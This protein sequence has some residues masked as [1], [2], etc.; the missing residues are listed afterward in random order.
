MANS[1]DRAPHAK[2]M[3]IDG[4]V[5]LPGP[6]DAAANSGDMNL[7]SSQMV[8]TADGALAPAPGGLGSVRP[9]RG[10]VPGLVGRGALMLFPQDSGNV[11]LRR[12]FWRALDALDYAVMQ[13]RLGLVD[14]LRGP[15][16]ETEADRQ[17][18]CDREDL[19]ARCDSGPSRQT[20]P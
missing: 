18:G 7:I 11:R 14:A 3:V 9:V 1:L 20:E 5:T 16:P 6:R 8:A 12:S 13:A 10:L 19:S 17:R 15:E 2:A 4:A